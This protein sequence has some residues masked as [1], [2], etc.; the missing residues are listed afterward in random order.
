[1]TDHLTIPELST[2]GPRRSRAQLT[3]GLVFSI[4]AVVAIGRAAPGVTGIRVSNVSQL[5]AAATAAAVATWRARRTPIARAH[6]RLVA[7]AAG[8]WAAGQ[9]VWTIAQWNGADAPFPS[10]ADVGFLAKTDEDRR[11]LERLGCRY[12]RGF[13]Y[14]AAVPAADV[15]A[16]IAASL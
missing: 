3:G 16:L 8:A 7:A 1:M 4:V 10:V 9:G 5:V 12:A 14:S 11:A 2:P 13:L 6:L 15:P